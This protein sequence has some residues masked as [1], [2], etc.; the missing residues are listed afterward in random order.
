MGKYYFKV[1]GPQDIENIKGMG[2]EWDEIENKWCVH[3]KEELDADL[4]DY[5]EPK[6]AFKLYEPIYLVSSTTTCWKCKKE[7][8]VYAI[9][10]HKIQLKHPNDAIFE[11]EDLLNY[12]VDARDLAENGLY[13]ISYVKD[14]G[15]YLTSYLKKTAQN[16]Y[17]DYSQ[18]LETH[19]IMN[20]CEHCSAKLGD[21][22]VFEHSHEPNGA[23]FS[24]DD[25]RKRIT[26]KPIF[27]L[28]SAEIKEANLSEGLWQTQSYYSEMV[29]FRK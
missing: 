21:Y 9:G 6:D 27:G 24:P 3:N 16:L 18:T 29:A 10:C 7:T 19:Y 25:G 4:I 5:L 14:F 1:D 12:I 2:A 8:K 15:T 22:A 26:A 28:K 17:R 11:P 23:A 13:L 20:H